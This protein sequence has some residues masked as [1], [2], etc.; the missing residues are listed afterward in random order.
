MKSC[1]HPSER[2]CDEH[3]G[4]L[5]RSARFERPYRV[6]PAPAR[7]LVVCENC[8]TNPQYPSSRRRAKWPCAKSLH[9]TPLLP[10]A[11]ARSRRPPLEGCGSVEGAVRRDRSITA[12]LRQWAKLDAPPH[13]LV[14]RTGW[15][16][17]LRGG[18]PRRRA[19]SGHLSNTIHIDKF[20]Q[21]RKAP[22][23][24][25]FVA[26]RFGPHA[27]RENGTGGPLRG[28]RFVAQRVMRG[29]VTS[30]RRASAGRPVPPAPVRSG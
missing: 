22:A 12:D 19:R 14:H 23:P 2:E 1:G 17:R 6:S 4:A 18:A 30:W 25:D 8:C 26:P 3:R 28:R 9:K 13:S 21:E 7:E 29:A 16:L 20:G 5:V 10:R 27:T 15:V 11:G 24:R